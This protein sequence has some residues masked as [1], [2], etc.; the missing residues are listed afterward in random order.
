MRTRVHREP[1]RSLL[2]VPLLALALALLPVAAFGQSPEPGMRA[3]WVTRWDFRTAADVERVMEQAA[4]LGVTDVIWQVRGQADAFYRSALEPWGRE[5]F[6]DLPKDAAEPGVDPLEQAVKHA[7]AKGMKLHAWFNVMPLWK[8]KTPPT[9]PKHPFNAHPAWRLYDASGA[10]QPLNDHYVIVNPVMPE[11]H[12]H[13]VAVA[14]DIVTRY[15]V[16]GFHMDY[17]RF[18]SDSMDKTKIYPADAASLALFKEATGLEGIESKENLAAYRDW[19]RTRITDLVRRLKQEAV[20]AREGVEFTAA[21]WRRPELGRETYLQ[22]GALWLNEGTLDRAFPMIYSAKDDQVAS[23]LAAWTAAAPGKR[24]TIGLG[25]YMHAPDQSPRQAEASM[26]GGSD[27][28]AIFAYA[29]MYES[30]NPLQERDEAGVRSRR[31][32]LEHV[33]RYFESLKSGSK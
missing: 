25:T 22:D 6:H 9:D 2:L 7:H 27:G 1:G 24:I 11:V 8:D 4:A 32:R 15:D 5:L 17:V 14:R 20:S 21:V 28:F 23:D 33:A 3:M 18:V 29:G 16:D 26:A 30:V 19:I 12:D 13:L 10:A 31:E